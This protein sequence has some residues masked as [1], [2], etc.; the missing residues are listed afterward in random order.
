MKKATFE[1]REKV[2][3]I[4]TESFKNNPHMNCIIKNDCHKTR[5][6]SILAEYVFY[7]GWRRDGLFLTDDEQGFVIIHENKKLFSDL[8]ELIFKLRLILYVFTLSRTLKVVRIES[9]IKANRFKGSNY[10]YIW[11]LGV[12]DQSLGSNNARD[13]MKFVFDMSAER[14]LPLYVETTVERNA[15]I[16]NRYG[17][18]SYYVVHEEKEKLTVWFMQRRPETAKDAGSQLAFSPS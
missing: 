15:R 16:Y 18:E 1:D 7:S 14:R 5:R 17:F 2:V 11:F 8:K 13:M 10:L 12:S 3:K 4:I 9:M 6:L